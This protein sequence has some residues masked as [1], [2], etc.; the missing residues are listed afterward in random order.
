MT[1]SSA[2]SSFEKSFEMVVDYKVA[3]VQWLALP[4]AIV[5][6]LLS[7]LPRCFH[8]GS[9]QRMRRLHSTSYLDALRG[10]A[11]FFVINYHSFP[12]E[13][14]WFVNLPIIRLVRS[15]IGMVALFFVISGYVLSIK[16][17]SLAR[18]RK[19]EAFLDHLSSAVFRR[20]I[21]LFLPTFVAL[22]VVAVLRWL[23]WYTP[24]HD[25]NDNRSLYTQMVEFLFDCSKVANPFAKT[26]FYEFAVKA[27]HD[28]TY[29]GSRYLHVLWTI[30]TEFRGSMLVYAFL[31][32]GCRM[33][34]SS[35][36][37][38]CAICIITSYYWMAVYGAMFLSGV[39][40]ADLSLSRSSDSPPPSP[41]DPPRL[42]EKQP[43]ETLSATKKIGYSLAVVTS[44]FILSY[45][46]D[47]PYAIYWPWPYIKSHL[48][49]QY[50]AHGELKKIFFPSFGAPLLIWALESWPTLQK[51]FMW[52]F[53][54][55]LGEISFG[56]YL[57]HIPVI[58]SLGT[59]L[60]EPFRKE[61][62]G[63]SL[64]AYA[65]ETIIL[66]LAVLW[67]AELFTHVDKK[68]V[69]FARYAEGKV[70]RPW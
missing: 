5:H 68:C 47:K 6:V 12:Y 66:R 33:P 64:W 19:R 40:L 49:A 53:S 16:L 31:T 36:M 69:G 45:P 60:L 32:V 24:E 55:Y 37:T 62:L 57:M 48:P 26:G 61:Y 59:N 29:A 9:S 8:R 67:A 25:S 43:Q 11:A 56:V 44:L 41:A 52:E 70:F 17:L 42:C 38:L 63:E 13:K 22:A 3:K 46:T 27:R 20:Y 39:F 14:T 10:Y 4:G 15:G 28:L 1:F 50:N 21:R 30:P 51:P 58:W 2:R 35:R 7:L 54:Q 65:P 34:S 18:Q 23:D